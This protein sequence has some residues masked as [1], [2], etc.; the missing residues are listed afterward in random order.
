MN[1]VTLL[2]FCLLGCTKPSGDT[3]FQAIDSGNIEILKG[4]RAEANAFNIHNS[5]GQ[6]PLTYIAKSDLPAE[7]KKAMVSHLLGVGAN[8]NILNA[9][10]E[11][12]L[13]VS[14]RFDRFENFVLSEFLLDQGVNI[15]VRNKHK[16]TIAFDLFVVGTQSDDLLEFYIDWFVARGGDL[17]AIDSDGNSV[18]LTMIS[19]VLCDEKTGYLAHDFS[20]PIEYL[21]SKGAEVNVRNKKGEGAISLSRQT[22]ADDNQ[23]ELLKRYGARE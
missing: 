7:T 3:V 23:V 4:I 5:D 12:V 13:H 2:V 15:N 8:P 22:N 1:R 9:D 18:L 11:T 16:Q 19:R 10:G 21:I 6:T 14:S 20:S 17:N